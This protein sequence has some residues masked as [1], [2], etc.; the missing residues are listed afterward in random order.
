MTALVRL[1]AIACAVGV[2]GCSQ[3]TRNSPTERG[4]VK[5]ALVTTAADGNQYRLSNGTVSVY[6]MTG[7]FAFHQDITTDASSLTFSVPPDQYNA[8]LNSYSGLWTLD[9]LAPDGTVAEVVSATLVTPLPVALSVVANQTTQLVFTFEVPSVGTVTFDYGGVQTTID[10]QFGQATSFTFS[11]AHTGPVDA[12]F[13]GPSANA[14][15]AVLPSTGALIDSMLQ[16]SV[17]VSWY[18]TYG[19][20]YGG[21]TVATA[22]VKLD[23]AWA[24]GSSPGMIDLVTESIDLPT[25]TLCLTDDGTPNNRIALNTFNRY[26]A[27]ITPT[28]STITS[29]PLSFQSGFYATLPTRPFNY[30]AGTLDLGQ[31]VTFGT[32]VTGFQLYASAYDSTIGDYWY[33]AFEG[34]LDP[35]SFTFV[36]Q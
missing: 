13:G 22:C 27:P 14:L 34:G 9:R 35:A 31:L 25:S 2:A 26:G 5:V 36:A 1:A 24:S 12:Y 17:G 32:Q 8:Y 16:G 6:A 7:S 28:F 15:M 18:L 20:S 3:E 21:Q 23:S 19:S 10:V 4:V 33:S 29:Q 30:P 11:L